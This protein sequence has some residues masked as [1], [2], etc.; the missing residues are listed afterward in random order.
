LAELE[1][2]PIWPVLLESTPITI[3]VLDHERRVRYANLVEHGFDRNAVLGVPIDGL[4]PAG[5]RARITGLIDE[6][7]RTGKPRTY[8]TRLVTPKGLVLYFVR[9]KALVID[10]VIR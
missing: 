1:F 3:A 9:L 8:E 4:L 2:E 6:V 7:L 10:G 5:D